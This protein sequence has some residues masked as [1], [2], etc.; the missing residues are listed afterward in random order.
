MDV[1]G[2]GVFISHCQWEGVGENYKQ[3]DQHV[4]GK[5]NQVEGTTKPEGHSYLEFDCVSRE[6]EVLQALK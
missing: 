4:Y 6:Q 3:R 5:S 2:G 1:C